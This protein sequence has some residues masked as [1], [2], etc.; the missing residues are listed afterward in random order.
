MTSIEQRD[1]EEEEMV[2]EE[3]RAEACR[4]KSDIDYL[5]LNY[6]TPDKRKVKDRRVG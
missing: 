5:L 3:R 1:K 4:R 2:V 6:D